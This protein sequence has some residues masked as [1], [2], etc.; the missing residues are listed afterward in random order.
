MPSRDMGELMK[1]PRCM[2]TQHPDNAAIPF[3]SDSSVMDG[4]TEVKE[5]FYAYY[6]LGCEEQMWDC[7]GKEV[8]SFVVKKL[9]SRYEYFFKEKT[10]GEDVFLTLRVPNPEVERNEG[11][12]LLE[13]LESIPRNFDAC[14]AFYGKDVAPIF[15]VI[16]PMTTSAASL[17]RVYNYYKDF[18]AGKGGRKIA[19]GN[20]TVA[21][22]VGELKPERI[23]MIPL[24][25]DKETMGK[26][27]A[28]V[29]EYISDK[30]LEYQRVFLARSDPALNYG[31]LSTVLLIKNAVADLH[32]LEEKSGVSIYPIIGA[33]SAPFRGNLKPA[34]VEDFMQSYPNVQT[35]TLQSAFKYDYRPEQVIEAVRKIREAKR[36]APRDVDKERSMRIVERV[37]AEYR[38]QI[39]LLAPLIN[40]VARYVPGRR[41]RKLHVGLFGYSRGSGEV[42]LPRAI[43]F[44]A[45]L[46]SIGIPP[47]MLGLDALEEKDYE[48]IHSVY[49]GFERDLK[50]ALVY[51]NKENL[52]LFPEIEKKILPVLERFEFETDE[53]HRALSKYILKKVE[54]GG[55]EALQEEIVKAAT[56]RKFLG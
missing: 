8:D 52:K 45:A 16:L 7:E 55:H 32:A 53:P 25:E 48:Y 47:E 35:L 44:C 5:A 34:N 12:V 3:F 49:P 9:L 33:G 51:L 41:K 40:R 6:D 39:S 15:E 11:K 23:N 31:S 26:A 1:V 17:N 10:L 50:D 13:A 30:D 46:Y 14:R 2:S 54:N 43:T 28:I 38:A 21:E 4:E 27:A 36:G 37:S 20:L 56:M 19:G 42:K 24:L 22:W 29:E 18:V